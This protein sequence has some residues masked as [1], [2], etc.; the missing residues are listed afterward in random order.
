MEDMASGSVGCYGRMAFAHGGL[1]WRPGSSC[2]EGMPNDLVWLYHVTNKALTLAKERLTAW[3]RTPHPVSSRLRRI[4]ACLVSSSSQQCLSMSA[5]ICLRSRAPSSGLLFAWFSF[6][7][8]SLPL[9]HLQPYFTF[10][11]SLRSCPFFSLSPQPHHALANTTAQQ[12]EGDT[13]WQFP[14]E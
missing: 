1:G 9:S 3:A 4:V 14:C 11:L 13:V 2:P 7:V 12:R 8:S 5:I 6:S 10:F